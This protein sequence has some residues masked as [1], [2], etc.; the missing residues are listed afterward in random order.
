MRPS[1]KFHMLAGTAVIAVLSGVPTILPLTVTLAVA[2]AES[3]S[4]EFRTAL[5]PYGTF[6]RVARWGDVWVPNNVPRNWRPYTV[7]R[8][9]QSND[10]GWYWDSDQSEAAWGW[11]TFH[12]G[13]WVWTDE[14]GW[15]WIPGRDWGPAWVDW[16]RGS[17]YVGWAPLP[18]DDIIAEERDDPQYWTFVEPNDFLAPSIA[19]VFIAPEP[20]FFRDTVVVNETVFVRDRG[21]AV[22]PGV[23][24]AF[25]AAA[26]GRPIPQFDVRPRVF[27][28][29]AQ[30]PGAIQVQAGDLRREDFR[31]S[32][33]R[34]SNIRAT[35]NVIR[36]A[37]NVPQPQA[38][39]R[40]EHGRLGQNPPQ[41]ATGVARQQPTTPQGGTSATTPEQ[42]RGATAPP[43]SS[44]QP[45][46]SPKVRGAAGPTPEQRGRGVYDRATP[47]GPAPERGPP[48]RGVTRPGPMP[49]GA[50]REH[51]AGGPP[52]GSGLYNR[53]PGGPALQGA[54]HPQGGPAGR[55]PQAMPHAQGAPG[56]APHAGG[57]N[58]HQR[59]Q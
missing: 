2:Q 40:N 30:L 27:A 7:G 18:P 33:A 51:G 35:S 37:A 41:A 15:A 53:A 49:G 39:G 4:V 8:W 57:G 44:G 28:G 42:Q 26:I 3:I 14:V 55:A 19:T 1:P 6:Q 9:V 22:N 45:P 46:R 21:F 56:G 13:R 43:T 16:R 34:Q 36:P 23:E 17:R 29:T 11:V 38:L 48:P 50:L 54:P 31:R 59:G 32:F 52:P 47:P 10:Y 20:V 24:P 12:Y 58:G 25:L 5:E